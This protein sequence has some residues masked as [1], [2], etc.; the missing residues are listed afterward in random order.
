MI[1]RA[2]LASLIISCLVISIVIKMIVYFL[3]FS[4][5]QKYLSFPHAVRF[6]SGSFAC[7]SKASRTDIKKPRTSLFRVRGPG[8]TRN[9]KQRKLAAVLRKHLRLPLGIAFEIFQV[10]NLQRDKKNNRIG[11]CGRKK[12]VRKQIISYL[13]KETKNVYFCI[14]K[15][16]KGE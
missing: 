10:S 3:F 14:R 4:T 9:A 6:F 7:P 8:K 2:L 15:K 1:T 16:N 13:Q 5:S 12:H 11:C